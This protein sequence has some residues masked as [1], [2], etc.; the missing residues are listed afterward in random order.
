MA[1]KGVIVV[2]HLT[3]IVNYVLYLLHQSN[4]SED[5]NLVY[6][7]RARFGGSLKYLTNWNVWLQAMYFVIALANDIFGSEARTK[8]HSSATQKIRDFMFYSVGFP[9]GVFV[10]SAFW[11]IYIVDRKLIFPEELDR[12]FPPITNHMMHTTPLV[13]Q[14]LEMLLIFHLQPKRLHGLR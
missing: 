9:T 6:P 3:V 10:T 8:E 4:V 2:F 12:Y 1:L 13:S 14:L 5:L 11:S 7:D